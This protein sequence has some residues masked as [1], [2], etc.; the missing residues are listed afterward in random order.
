MFNVDVVSADCVRRYSV[1]LAGAA[2]W[3]VTLE[4]NRSIRWRETHADWH[5]VERALARVRREVS[6]LLERGWTIRAV[7]P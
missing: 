7:S 4:E 5:R 3:E 1:A 2:G 6:D